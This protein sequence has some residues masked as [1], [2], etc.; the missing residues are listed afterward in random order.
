MSIESVP[1][2]VFEPGWADKPGI[3]ECAHVWRS[4]PYR[5]TDALVDFVERCERCGCPRCPRDGCVDRRH[6]AGVHV[7]E[8][9]HFEPLGGVLAPEPVA[10]P[11]EHLWTV[12]GLC[13]RCGVKAWEVE[14]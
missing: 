9:G 5:L 13:V 12:A 11:C 6:H 8:D 1:F 3:D 10:R 2:Q 7:F 4:V 14:A